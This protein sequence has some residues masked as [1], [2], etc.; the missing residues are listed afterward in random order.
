M[1]AFSCVCV[2]MCLCFH[3]IFLGMPVRV[4]HVNLEIRMNLMRKS[5]GIADNYYASNQIY[6]VT[7]N[8]IIPHYPMQR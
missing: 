3:Y 7:R 2:C 8:I 6:N 1:Y 5:H 4:K